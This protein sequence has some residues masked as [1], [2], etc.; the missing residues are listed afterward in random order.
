MDPF[1]IADLLAVPVSFVEET[2]AADA[3][4]QTT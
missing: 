2:A 4:K 1:L 3:P